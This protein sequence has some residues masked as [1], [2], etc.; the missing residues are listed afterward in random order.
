MRDWITTISIVFALW[1]LLNAV[2]VWA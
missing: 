2:G 1:A